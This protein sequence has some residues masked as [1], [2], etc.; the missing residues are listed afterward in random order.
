MSNY[1]ENNTDISK[2]L[3][4]GRRN[5]TNVFDNTTLVNCFKENSS[6]VFNGKAYAIKNDT[7]H[8]S[9]SGSFIDNSN[10]SN[11]YY[12]L[13]V[14]YAPSNYSQLY[15]L[16]D[17]GYS[18]PASKPDAGVGVSYDAFLVVD[19]SGRLR[20]TTDTNPN[21]GVQLGSRTIY[22]TK[23]LYCVLVGGGGGGGSGRR[24]LG[25]YVPGGGGGGG[26]V[27]TV[28]L[29]IPE[30]TNKILY[31]LEY[32]GRGVPYTAGNGHLC[33][34]A[35]GDT[36]VTY[37]SDSS[38]YVTAKGGKGGDEGWRTNHKD[39]IASG[40]QGGEVVISNKCSLSTSPICVVKSFRGGDGGNSV[41]TGQSAYY[42]GGA[43][44]IQNL[45][46]L[47][48]YYSDNGSDITCTCFGGLYDSNPSGWSRISGGGGG[49]SCFLL[50][51]G[52]VYIP[53][54]T[55]IKSG[56]NGV[57]S[58]SSKGND[59]ISFGGGGG[60]GCATEIGFPY[61]YLGGHGMPGLIVFYY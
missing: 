24:D 43:C 41:Y 2:L 31:K 17:D 26:A 5:Y 10:V 1:K 27:A 50:S 38:Y 45:F 55:D 57:V 52:I 14:G 22:N 30:A 54:S 44:V 47:S 18:T 33:S 59:G 32:G 34:Y 23:S 12:P 46:G 21:S 56:G 15:A 16:Y 35:G 37:Y 48:Q 28:L 11:K 60:G 61:T 39:F 6:N 19:S 40:G 49:S 53:S 36:T 13:L 7:W 29:S 3:E 8:K 42:K 4:D 51:N 20:V 9:Y 25:G 58:L